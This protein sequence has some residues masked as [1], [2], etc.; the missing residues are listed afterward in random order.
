MT[1][2]C[3]KWRLSGS[4][5]T[6]DFASSWE[7]YGFDSDPPNAILETATEQRDDRDG[8]RTARADLRRPHRHDHIQ[9]P[10]ALRCGRLDEATLYIDNA[11]NTQY[12]NTSN[13]QYQAV[14]LTVQGTFNANQTVTVFV[15]PMAA[16][17]KI[18]WSNGPDLEDSSS[19]NFFV[20]SGDLPLQ[21]FLVN[22]G[23]ISTTAGPDGPT[24]GATI[25]LQ[26]F[27][28]ATSGVEDFY[29]R[30]ESDSGITVTAAITDA[31]PQ[32]L[33]ATDTLFS[34]DPD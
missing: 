33:N 21:T 5:A 26:L 15:K 10:Q 11:N 6:A 31:Q 24:D 25:N 27:L 9:G 3:P 8:S 16:Q 13:T 29:L 18:N 34:F 23:Y 32:I 7:S 1:I 2:W 14:T 28:A 4:F 30:T 17:D 19:L 12:Q 20:A 22:P